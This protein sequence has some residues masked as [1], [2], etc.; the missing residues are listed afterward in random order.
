LPVGGKNVLPFSFGTKGVGLADQSNI[1]D[2]K[3]IQT[4]NV[5]WLL[6]KRQKPCCSVISV[7]MEWA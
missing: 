4:A 6:A 1:T 5:R 2:E 3:Q 7:G